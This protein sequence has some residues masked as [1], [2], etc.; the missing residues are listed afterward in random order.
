[1]P[2]AAQIFIKGSGVF[3]NVSS[4]SNKAKLRVLYEVAAIGYLI[5]KGEGKTITKGKISL[6]EHVV[7]G[8]DER[9]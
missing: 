9:M 2:D 7:D 8:Y 5:E 6:L 1:M 3:C 4:P